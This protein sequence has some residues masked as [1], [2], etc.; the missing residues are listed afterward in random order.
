MKAYH[1]TQW[2]TYHETAESRKYDRLQNWTANPHK[3][4]GM[5][6][7]QIVRS[8]FRD[9]LYAGWKLLCE[10]SSKNPRATRGWLIRDGRALSADDLSLL[11]GFTKKTFEMVLDFFCQAEVGWLELVEYPG[12]PAAASGA[13]GGTG[14]QPA[15]ASGT[16]GAT[17]GKRLTEKRRR[18]KRREEKKREGGPLSGPA[19]L[20]TETDVRTWAVKAKVD[21]D[22]AAIKLAEAT[23]RGALSVRGRVVD[24][25]SRFARYWREEGE[26]WLK[27][28]K[29]GAA[30]LNGHPPGWQEGDAG[31]WWTDPLADVRAAL[32]GAALGKNEKTAARLREVIALR[33]KMRR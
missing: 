25:R 2:N 27:K 14:K 15:A 13:P 30:F 32:A 3:H 11:T 21:P 5:G 18:E 29:N 24:W 28:Q 4:D 26:G 23:E 17:S 6:Y 7:R 9:S 20:L 8:K 12:E 10:V 22:F 1:I 31:I 19:A 16:P 33:E